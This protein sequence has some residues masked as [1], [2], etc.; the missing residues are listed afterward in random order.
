MSK[1]IDVYD[2]VNHPFEL[3]CEKLRA[4][5]LEVFHNAT[6]VAAERARTIVSELRVNIAGIE[7]GKEI[8]IQLIGITERPKGPLG[9]EMMIELEWEAADR[10]RLF[11][12]MKAELRIF[13]L[14]PSET[15]LH[16]S[17]NYEPPLGLVGGL[18]DSV[19]GH[20][21]AEASILR[22]IRDVAAYLRSELRED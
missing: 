5:A 19:A 14:T 15:Q 22:F 11:P 3:V 16:L 7:V 21:I 4:D 20:R 13:P 17:G 2:Y 12:F 9:P 8:E 10:P 6:K 1:K 18:I